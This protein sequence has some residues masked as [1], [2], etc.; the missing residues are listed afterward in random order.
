MLTHSVGVLARSYS[1][2]TKVFKTGLLVEDF[3]DGQF[4]GEAVLLADNC[5][6]S[7]GSAD[8]TFQMSGQGITSLS[9]PRLRTIA[10]VFFY[11]NLNKITDSSFD[12]LI[13]ITST[14]VA[15][16]GI[17]LAN[18]PLGNILFPSLESLTGD[19]GLVELSLNQG[20]P[21]STQMR[22]ALFP[23]LQTISGSNGNI[24]HLYLHGNTNLSLVELPQLNSIA[25]SQIRIDNCALTQSC[26]NN[27]LIQL[28]SIDEADS[29]VTVDLSGGT[30]A[31]P[32][33]L[34]LI[35][36]NNLTGRGCHITT[37]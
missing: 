12:E 36:K 19:G 15:T 22:T 5:S 34:G 24:L 33:G 11:F 9:A 32:S 18:N 17:T 37:N 14:G 20:T 26:V 10:N 2:I 29:T 3:V 21:T 1:G 7:D 35:A 30:S 27:L 6:D 4:S 25:Y 23:R 8:W 16:S 13:Q 28:D 31:A